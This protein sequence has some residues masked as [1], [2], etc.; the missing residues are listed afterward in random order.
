MYNFNSEN[1]FFFN[2][3]HTRAAKIFFQIEIFKNTLKVNG[4]ICEFG[5]FKGN[6]LNRLIL[7]RDFYCNNKKIFAFDTFKKIELDKKHIDFKKYKKFL[8]DSN[9]TQCTLNQLTSKLK[10]K[11]MFSKIK[12]VKGNVIKTLKLQ[13]I[14]KISFILLDLDIYEPTL[15]VLNYA[16][17]KM[18]KDG[19][20]LLDNYKVFDGETKAV[21]EFAKINKLKIHK[22]KFFKNF[23]FLKK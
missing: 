22:K 3:N 12:L 17:P 14:K 6:S 16:W 13:K 11:K 18:S 23:Y 10:L 15:H 8:N 4:D 5:V 7:L 1:D 20:I 9:N 21:N 2:I 19:I